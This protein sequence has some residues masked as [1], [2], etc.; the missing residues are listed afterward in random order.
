MLHHKISGLSTLILL[1]SL[2]SVH[3]IAMLARA[4]EPVPVSG[5]VL[6]I[7]EAVDIAKRCVLDR[8]IRL[9]GSSIESA[10]FE[11]NPRGDRGPFWRVTWSYSR[12]VKGGQVFVNVFVDRTCELTHGE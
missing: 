10:H 8:N 9:V 12:E 5:L 3:V 6:T 7:E 4:N 2:A 11:R 1:M